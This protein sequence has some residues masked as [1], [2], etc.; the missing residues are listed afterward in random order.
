VRLFARLGLRVQLSWSLEGIC[1]IEGT[2]RQVLSLGFCRESREKE[3]LELGEFLFRP[4][5]ITEILESW[6]PCLL[7]LLGEIEPG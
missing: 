6:T 7:S 4:W 5:K 1:C 2:W 3:E